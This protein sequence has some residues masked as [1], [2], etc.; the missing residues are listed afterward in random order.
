MFSTLGIAF[1]SLESSEHIGGI[2]NAVSL[3]LCKLTEGISFPF[4]MEKKKTKV[5]S[6]ESLGFSRSGSVENVLRSLIFSSRANENLT[7]QH[8]KT[9]SINDQSLDSEIQLS[10]LRV[11]Y[12]V[13][14]VMF[15]GNLCLKQTL[16]IKMTWLAFLPIIYELGRENYLINP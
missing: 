3:L 5:G 4:N 15:R 12:S 14:S 11:S 9:R 7:E 1:G 13:T 8:W 6:C 2:C 16:I 10:F